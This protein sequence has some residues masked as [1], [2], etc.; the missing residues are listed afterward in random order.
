MLSAS[1][2]KKNRVIEKH[3]RFN[4][5]RLML[6]LKSRPG[7]NFYKQKMRTRHTN[8]LHA[9]VLSGIYTSAVSLLFTYAI[10]GSFEL[11]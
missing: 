8:I 5:S 6:P 2:H 11:M 7:Y 3:L 10:G 4:W 1:N 9:N